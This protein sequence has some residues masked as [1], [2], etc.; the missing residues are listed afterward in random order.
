M[1]L[2]YWYEF[3]TGVLILLAVLIF[4]SKGLTALAILAFLPIIM[5]IKKIKPDER[6]K[7]LFFRSTQLIINI[8]VFSII[9]GAFV[10]GL[11]IKDLSNMDSSALGI[12]VAVFL[13]FVSSIRL[14]YYYKH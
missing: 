12:G 2:R 5:R 8:I 3:I 4:G 10:F 1:L 7:Q 6:E 9:I 13:I 11:K 14:F